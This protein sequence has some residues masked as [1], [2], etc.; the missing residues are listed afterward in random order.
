M[1]FS[2]EDI[3]RLDIPMEDFEFV[4]TLKS[5]ECMEGNFPDEFFIDGFFGVFMLG[6]NV[7]DISSF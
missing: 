4:E 7:R 6:D 1:I 5:F 3:S 2:K